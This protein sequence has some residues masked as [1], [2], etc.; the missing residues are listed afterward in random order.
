MG[1]VRHAL[2]HCVLFITEYAV[3]SV[4]SVHSTYLAL[5]RGALYMLIAGNCLPNP[6]IDEIDEI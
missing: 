5:I 4:T 2:F 1:A 6:P 3:R